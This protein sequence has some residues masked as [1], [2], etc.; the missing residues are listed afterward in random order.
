MLSE[1][2]LSLQAIEAQAKALG[3]V[4]EVWENSYRIDLHWIKRSKKAPPGTGGTV[5]QLLC[6]YADQC[7]KMILLQV[8]NEELGAYYAGYGFDDMDSD[9]FENDFPDWD[10]IMVRRPE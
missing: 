10:E 5:V 4:I 6:D 1:S 2:V 7:K 3:V 8:E 9:E